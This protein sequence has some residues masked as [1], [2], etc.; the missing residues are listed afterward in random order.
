MKYRYVWLMMILMMV[1]G[2]VP[3]YLF[4]A[5]GAMIQFR[6]GEREGEWNTIFGP[7][8][9][10]VP[11]SSYLMV[12]LAGENGVPDPPKCDGSP[13][14]DDI[15]PTGNS[16]NHLYIHDVAKE[17]P[18]T[19][20]GNIY[21]PGHFLDVKPAEELEEPAINPGDKFYFRAFNNKNPAEATHYNDMIAVDKKAMSIYEVPI[22]QGVSLFSAILS[23]GPPQSLCP[24]KK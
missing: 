15:Q 12:I 24:K 2:L 6:T 8:G 1:L 23:F 5:Q 13:G 18:F 4:G 17:L 9:K 16:F 21:A 20:E 22:I 19:P 11:D 7:D 3:G 14:G 10:P